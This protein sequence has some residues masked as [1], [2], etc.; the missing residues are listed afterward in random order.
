M[1]ATS[2]ERIHMVADELSAIDFCYEQGW[3]DGLPVVPPVVARVN[4]MLAATTLP[5]DHVLAE[6]LPTKRRCR[7][8]DAAVNAVMA[9][10]LPAYFPVIVAALEAVNVHEYNFHASGASTGGSAPLLILSGPIVDELG[11]NAGAN[12]FG[13]GNRANATLGR[14]L[15]LII[16]NVFKMTPGIADHSTQGFP[17]KYSFC[18][19]EN[20]LANPWE[21]LNVEL[22][23]PA[24]VS[25]V[26]VFAGSGTCSLENHGGGQP[27]QILDTFADTI[28]SYALITPGESVLVLS[29]EHARNI[30]AAGW[31]KQQ[32][33]EYL[34]ARACRPKGVL[35][36][37]GKTKDELQPGEEDEMMHRG[38]SPDDFLVLVAGGDAGGHSTYVQSWSRGRSSERQTRP[39]HP[40]TT[41]PVEGGTR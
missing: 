34:F 26:T 19:A 29:P 3:T 33:R 8:F 18:I 32:V 30:A 12:V 4:A 2:R 24:D 37:L 25:T 13:P 28:G 31:T 17:G 10:C 21:P 40:G 39:I 41:A 6:H 14:T 36:R 9:G 20:A 16:L 35:Q 5:P 11:M 22:G 23:Y 38:L 15:R 27:E 1:E 7:V